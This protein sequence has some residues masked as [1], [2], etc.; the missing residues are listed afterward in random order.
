MNTKTKPKQFLELHGKSILV[1][2]L[3]Q[4]QQH[5]RIDGIVI[6]SLEGYI[7]YCWQLVHKFDLTKVAAIV[8][9]GENG[10]MSIF[11]GLKKAGELYAPD[12]TV[13]IH[14]GVR[15]LIDQETIS[16]CL[17]CV[18][19]HGSAIT[20]TSATETIT[21]RG[22][23]EEIGEIIER[24]RCQMARAPQCF[25]LKDILEAH[26]KAQ[27]ERKTDFIDS[28][29]LMRHYGHKLYSVEGKPENIK[30]TTPSD[31]YIFRAIMDA[32]ENSQILG[33]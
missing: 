6:A 29:C 31:F 5:K 26:K 25:V 17:D 11:N 19:A 14:D 23:G 13:L 28:A 21:M 12:S 32:R 4:F 27:L 10:Q 15:P 16:R 2:T 9:G 8:P 24:S 30:I 1:Y 33:L 20:V 18:N 7:D 3:E 22:E